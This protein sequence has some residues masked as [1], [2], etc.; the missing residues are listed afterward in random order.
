MK[1]RNPFRRSLTVK[2]FFITTSVLLISI[3]II[4]LIL[5]IFIPSFYASYKKN[6]LV[7]ESKAIIRTIADKQ[8]TYKDGFTILR[9]FSQ[10]NNISVILYYQDNPVYIASSSLPFSSIIGS[11]SSDEDVKKTID[12]SKDYFYS[13]NSL[14]V[15]KDASY[16]AHFSTPIQPVS[17]VRQVLISF[18][19]YIGAIILL[20]SLLAS[21]IYANVITKPLVEINKVAKRMTK[22]EFGVKSDVTSQDELG[23]LALSLNTLSSNLENTMAELKEANK[24]LK[25]DIEKERIRDE[26]RIGF[27]ATMSHEL[28]SPI[29]AIRGQLEGMLHNIGVYQN[30]DKYLE[31]SLNIVQDLEG[32]VKELLVTSK[33]DNAALA[34]KEEVL[35]ISPKLEEIIRNLEYLQMERKTKIEKDIQKNLM[36]RGDWGLLKRSFGNIIENAIRY[37]IDG[38]Q[39]QVKAYRKGRKNYVEVFNQGE[40]LLEEDLKDEKIFDA[41]Y[42][43]EQSRNRETGGSG[44]GLHIVKKILL[45]HRFRYSI[46]N[47][48]GGILFT[49]EMKSEPQKNLKK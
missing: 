4:Y 13:Y 3:S 18:L 48:E 5:Y 33:L 7:S 45:L 14:I 31:R 43:T 27:I 25:S 26:Q 36:I 46:K 44:L 38:G 6:F 30:R 24:A 49:V 2:N 16:S 32:L 9:Q 39:V 28:K 15:F 19:P 1:I 12:E 8:S 23:E 47:V 29:T 17:E 20:T 35:N 21:F 40:P 41:F 42:R 37:G 10:T 22:L 11:I 34:L